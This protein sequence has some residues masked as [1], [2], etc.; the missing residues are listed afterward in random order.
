MNTVDECSPVGDSNYP[1]LHFSPTAKQG[2]WMSR[3]RVAEILY[4]AIKCMLKI[5]SEFSPVFNC[6]FLHLQFLKEKKKKKKEMTF[7]FFFT[8][9]AVRPQGNGILGPRNGIFLKTGPRV[10]KS[11]NAVSAFSRHCEQ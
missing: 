1:S 4:S 2:G 11:E 5:L 6:C 7:S 8:L 3:K 9:L 10:G